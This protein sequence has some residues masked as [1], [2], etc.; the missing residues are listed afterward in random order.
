MYAYICTCDSWVYMY[1]SICLS[2]GQ[3]VAK[4]VEHSKGLDPPSWQIDPAWQMLFAVWAI[5]CS[6]QWPTTGPLRALVCAVLCVE[7]VYK[8]S[9]VAYWK[10]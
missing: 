8:R 10:A 2:R 1:G 7:S 9:L 3:N 5:F 6:N 4:V